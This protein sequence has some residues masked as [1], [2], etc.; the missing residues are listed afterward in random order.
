VRCWTRK[1][2]LALVQMVGD[3][4][5]LATVAAALG[6]TYPS[7]RKRAWELGTYSRRLR[8]GRATTVFLAHYRAGLSDP[9]IAARAGLTVNGVWRKRRRLRL[10]PNVRPGR[11][12]KVSK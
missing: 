8:E 7:V 1:E 5:T 2:E 12:R 4:S 10:P 11:P 6:R 3:G 9:E